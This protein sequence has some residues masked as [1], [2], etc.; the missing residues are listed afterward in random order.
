[1]NQMKSNEIKSDEWMNEAALMNEW[2]TWMN[3]W[4]NEMSEWIKWMNEWMNEWMKWDGVK[5][6]IEMNEWMKWLHE[7]MNERIN[8]WMGG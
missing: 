1:M 3:E 8:E 6:M 2:M 4:M 7:W 5:G